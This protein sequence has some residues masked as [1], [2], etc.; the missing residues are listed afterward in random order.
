M[1]VKRGT[2]SLEELYEK[3]SLVKHGPTTFSEA[4]QN[5]KLQAATKDD[6]EMIEKK[7]TWNLILRLRYRHVINV[8]WVLKT[9]I[10]LDGTLNKHKARLVVKAYR[11]QYGMNFSETFA[12]T[13]RHGK[14]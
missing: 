4:A 11:Q 9:K 1:L 5:K 14:N 12:S 2:K 7:M 3:A 6:L 10:N 13:V 8:K